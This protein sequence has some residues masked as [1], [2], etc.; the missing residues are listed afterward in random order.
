MDN[1]L[2]FN[3]QE[4]TEYI[5]KFGH[6]P[7][8]AKQLLRWIYYFNEDHF[9]VM[10]DVAKSFQ[11]TLKNN[12][13]IVTP[14]ITF[15]HLSLDGTRKWLLDVGEKNG[16]ETRSVMAGNISKQPV[17]K[18]LKFKK[19]RSLKNSDY[20]HDNSFVIGNHHEID[21][22]KREFIADVIINF[23]IKNQK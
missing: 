2:E 17:A 23:I 1:L 22:Q 14:E 7:Y 13:K 19:S 12:A 10:T 21:E 9:E 15:D 8:R 3:L 5:K 20:I 6:K 18:I 16:I 11:T 4:L